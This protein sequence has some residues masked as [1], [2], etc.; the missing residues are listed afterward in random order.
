MEKG[1]HEHLLREVLMNLERLGGDLVEK[2]QWACNHGLCDEP[3]GTQGYNNKC[4]FDDGLF[5][6]VRQVPGERGRWNHVVMGRG[7]EITHDQPPHRIPWKSDDSEIVDYA[8]AI[9][10]CVAS[11]IHGQER[12][13]LTCGGQPSS[14]R[15]YRKARHGS[16]LTLLVIVAFAA[17]LIVPRFIPD[18]SP[19]S[20][21]EVPKSAMASPQT[22]APWTEEPSTPPQIW[23]KIE[24]TK[25]DP[26]TLLS[27][28]SKDYTIHGLCLGITHFQAWEI[29]GKTACLMGLKDDSNPSRIW[30]YGRDADGSKKGDSILYLIWDPG[31]ETLSRITVFQGF[32]DSLSPTFRRLLTF[33]A[34]DDGSP[35]KR[36]LIGYPDR[37]AITLDLPA[38]RKLTGQK[39][40]TYFVTDQ[41]SAMQ[42]RAGRC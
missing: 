41:P 21:E 11:I 19:I 36:D 27:T 15:A 6:C 16:A 17:L 31:E 22:E 28:K 34:V 14:L 37:S 26:K 8:R 30:V 18:G 24:L 20:R 13:S 23:P 12:A 29:L 3:P 7:K 35:L 9:T 25:D 10:P 32:R 5:L 33:E 40:I 38:T 42:D 2:A 1:Q 39:H 4:K